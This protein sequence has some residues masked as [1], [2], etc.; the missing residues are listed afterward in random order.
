MTVTYI[1]IY[2]KRLQKEEEI[3]NL[4]QHISML[5]EELDDEQTQLAEAA[6]ELDST[7]KQLAMVISTQHTA[8]RAFGR[9]TD[10]S[11][12]LK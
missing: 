11:Q 5:E 4:Q 9:Q 3:Q 1:T 6:S 7:E 10:F 8:I 2:H 12:I